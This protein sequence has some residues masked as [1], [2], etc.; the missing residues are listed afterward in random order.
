M[1]P[2]PDDYALVVGVEHYPNYRSL[3][4]AIA[5]AEDFQK[6]LLDQDTGGGLDSSRC[7]TVLSQP[8]PVRPIQDEIDDR[9]ED[10]F[11]QLGD[12]LGRR[13]YV[14]FSGHGL[15]RA[16]IGN[17]LCLAKWS[18]QRRNAALDSQDYLNLL[19]GCGKFQEVVFFLDCCRVRE[20]NARGIPS[21]LGLA[22][23]DEASAASRSFVAYA[24][25]FLNAAY[26]AEIATSSPAGAVANSAL[27]PAV[28]GHF[29]RALLAGLR[30]GAAVV[31]GGV[32]ASKL[33]T[34]LEIET[35]RIALESGQTQTPEVVNGFPSVDEPVFGN[36]RPEAN[37][38]VTFTSE[39]RGRIV[40]E[41]PDLAIVRSGDSSEGTWQLTL[42]KGRY[43]LRE[44]ATGTE[45]SVPFRPAEG[46]QNVRF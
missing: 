21:T 28:R 30:G 35:P 20:I 43:M 4:G 46:V 29:T 38:V 27:A 5:D 23:P 39:R 6:W 2:S 12:S 7:K 24:T 25:E 9:L 16:N 31:T 17:D 26:E 32:P 13:I 37:L 40:M 3:T 44:E 19:A 36:A 1:A 11:K 14:Y 41:G 8:D 33:K 34:H 42:T 15:A 45:M 22:R 18:L 10:I